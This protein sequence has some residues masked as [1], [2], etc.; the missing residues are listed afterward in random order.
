MNQT[1]LETALSHH[2]KQGNIR[3]WHTVVQ[4]YLV[5]ESSLVLANGRVIATVSTFPPP[6][7]SPPLPTG[8]TRALEKGHKAPP[9][10]S[11]PAQKH[12]SDNYSVS[13]YLQAFL[14]TNF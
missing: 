3:Q 11:P 7:P 1:N 13:K 14:L 6:G 4:L 12:F 8:L 9:G 10:Q 2:K 5:I